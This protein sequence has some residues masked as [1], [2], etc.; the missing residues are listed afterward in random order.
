M[1][2]VELTPRPTKSKIMFS[3]TAL[4]LWQTS[5]YLR[6]AL[7]FLFLSQQ[8]RCEVIVKYTNC[9]ILEHEWIR[10]GI[11]T[12][13]AQ[14]DK[15]IRT[16][17]LGKILLVLIKKECIYNTW[18]NWINKLQE[19]VEDSEKTSACFQRG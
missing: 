15:K 1:Q 13:E 19:I 9:N 5:I 3:I 12:L 14:I 10:T 7:F 18:I 6:S 11:R 16:M 4:P 17:K 8:A 2:F